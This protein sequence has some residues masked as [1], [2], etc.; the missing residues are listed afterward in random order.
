M[1]VSSFFLHQGKQQHTLVFGQ[2]LKSS[3]DLS[4]GQRSRS[5]RHTP[6]SQKSVFYVSFYYYKYILCLFE[7]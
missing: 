6:K 1:Q 3:C 4:Q 5:N 2:S 7:A